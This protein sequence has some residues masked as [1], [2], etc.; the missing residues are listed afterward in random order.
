MRHDYVKDLWALPFEASDCNNILDSLIGQLNE[1]YMTDLGP[2]YVAKQFAATEE[3]QY[4]DNPYAGVKFIFVGGSHANRLAAAADNADIDC[5]NLT[6]Y[7][8]YASPL[9][10]LK[11]CQSS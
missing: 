8:A 6:V 10:V 11:I 3:S 5:C 2:T 4:S 7:L 9:L 1:N